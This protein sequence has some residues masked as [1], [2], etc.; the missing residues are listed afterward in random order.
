MALVAVLTTLV[1][2]PTG[3]IRATYGNQTSVDEPHYLLTAASLGEDFDLDIAN[4]VA[5]DTQRPFHEQPLAPQ[6]ATEASGRAV[7]PHDPGL[8]LILAAPMRLGG[9][10]AAKATL[11]VLAG[12]LAAATLWL[13][14]RR[15]DARPGPGAVV[16][17][18]LCASAPLV[19]YG[20]QVYPELPAAL[21]VV[22]GVAAASAPRGWRADLGTVVAVVVLPWLA[23]KYVPVAAVLAVVHLVGRW[24]SGDRRA[25]AWVAAALAA[26]G[27]LY[28]AAHLAW[29]GGLTVYAA[30]DFF[31]ANGSQLS[32]VGTRPDLLAR[33]ARLVGLW[34]DRDFGLAMW[35]PAW[36]LG[37][38][39]LAWVM[40]RRSRHWAVLVLVVAAGW[41]TATFVALTMHGWWFPGRQ[42]IVVLPLV[43]VAVASWVSH[44]PRTLVVA[45]A[46]GIAGMATTGWLLVDGLSQRLTLVVDFTLVGSPVFAFARV[47]GPDY[48]ADTMR[49][50]VLHAV[51]LAVLVAVGWWGWR[52]AV[53]HP[54]GPAPVMSGAGGVTD[55]R[56]DALSVNSAS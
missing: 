12:V 2:L 17:T 14:V 18:L 32:V 26:A 13:A 34:V 53:G 37:V 10:R 6:A 25:V 41:A 20:G 46:L 11:A 49:T 55:E 21:V 8:P 39:G 30:G 47:A 45:T 36:V 33:S 48:T 22:G 28:V 23:V 3:W 44:R 27:G 54:T 4:Q 35:Q 38:G 7:V 40:G 9:W 52:D 5:A 42:V 31:R 56:P 50:W 16:V 15:F 43:A 29:Y 24:R 51:W 19:V 1:A